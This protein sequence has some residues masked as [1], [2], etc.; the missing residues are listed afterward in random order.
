MACL[1]EG[2]SYNAAVIDLTARI[3]RAYEGIVASLKDQLDD[4]AGAM[5]ERQHR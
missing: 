2:I 3:H 1:W 4:S 5:Q